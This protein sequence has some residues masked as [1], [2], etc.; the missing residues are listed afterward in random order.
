MKKTLP[1]TVVIVLC[2]L[3]TS[4][5]LPSAVNAEFAGGAG[6]IEDPY[7]IRD[8][9]Q[10][11]LVGADQSSL[12]KHY[13]LV[14]DIDLDPNLPGREVYSRAPIGS[15]TRATGLPNSGC[16]RYGLHGNSEWQRPRDSQPVC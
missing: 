8:W 9:R 16:G 14:D 13:I 5:I 15:I 12:G 7:Q 11:L 1:K 3:L 2:W 6:T 10:L 4:V